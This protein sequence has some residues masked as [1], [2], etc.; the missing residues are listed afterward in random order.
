MI[1]DVADPEQIEVLLIEDNPGDARLVY[2]YVSDIENKGLLERM[3]GSDQIGAMEVTGVNDLESGLKQLTRKTF[4][5]VLLDLQLPDSTG[6][7]TI[8]R[9]ID[10][11]PDIP[12][13]V[14]TGMPEQELGVTAVARGAQ[15]FLPKNDLE[16]RVLLK[17]VQ[18]AIER[19][20]QEQELRQQSEQLAI[21]NRLMRHDVRNDVSLIVGR[22]QELTEYV[23]PRGQDR[24]EEIIQSGNHVLQL[25]QS[26]G[27]AL[28][29]LTA[30]NGEALTA[31]AL[32]PIV[33]QEVEQAAARYRGPEITMGRIPDV[34]VRA[35]HLLSSVIA[36][37][38]NNGIFYNDKDVPRITINAEAGKEMVTLYVADNGPGIPHSLRQRLFENEI[39]DPDRPGLG[40][41]L[42]L[43][44]R[45]IDQY[46]G[47]IEIEDNDPEGSV[48]IVELDRA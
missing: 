43:V 9:V 36:N 27:E 7:E 44:Y 14:L 2:E 17:T 48:F 39:K 5:I 1:D 33:K 35:N 20:E 30:T 6:L 16:P 15:D 18:Y 31:I 13:V 10:D 38:I 22:A 41:G 4:D 23:D 12:V 3:R 25:T 32:K 40:I 26:I 45:F 19:K 37:L 46:D 47:S 42:T 29:A 34:D 8:D 28:D 11:A 24:L 21:F